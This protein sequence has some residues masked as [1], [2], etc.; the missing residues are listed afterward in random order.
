MTTQCR[1]LQVTL[2]HDNRLQHILH[3][4]IPVGGKRGVVAGEVRQDSRSLDDCVFQKSLA[5]PVSN[6]KKGAGRFR[7]QVVAD[8][9]Q[10]E[11]ALTEDTLHIDRAACAYYQTLKY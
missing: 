11:T 4:R 8:M 3:D 2:Q 1:Q 9:G 6:T 10:K 7:G 5:A